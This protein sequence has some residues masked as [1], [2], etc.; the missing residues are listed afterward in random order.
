MTFEVPDDLVYLDSHEWIDPDTGRVGV[1][2]YA[3]DELGDIVFVD[4]PREGDTVD[5]EEAFGVIESIKAVS[6]L[7]AP[8]DGDVVAVN[9]ELELAPEMVN[10]DP[11][12]DGWMIELEFGDDAF[13]GLMTAEEYREALE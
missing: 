9:D 2:D 7:Y 3:Q 11:Y 6:D 4:L 8:V 1:S 13:D 12:G 10:D 5:A